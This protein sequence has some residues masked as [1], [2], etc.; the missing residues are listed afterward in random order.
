MLDPSGSR[1][2]VGDGWFWGRRVMVGFIGVS[3]P[4]ELS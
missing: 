4:F 3:L 2:S 1:V